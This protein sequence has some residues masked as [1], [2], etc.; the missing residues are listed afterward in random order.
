MA[1]RV[2]HGFGRRRQH[3]PRGRGAVGSLHGGPAQLLRA[4]SRRPDRLLHAVRR[5]AVPRGHQR[6]ERQHRARLRDRRHEEH[7]RRCQ[8]KGRAGGPRTLP[9]VRE[10]HLRQRV[11]RPGQGGGLQQ[12]ARSACRRSS[13][14]SASATRASAWART[15]C[16]RAR[17]ATTRWRPSPT[18]SC[19]T[20][21][22]AAARTGVCPSDWRLPRLRRAL[23][24]GPCGLRASRPWPGRGRRCRSRRRKRRRQR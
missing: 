1:R 3:E 2:R 12:A 4:V 5:G 13:R 18:T 19:A 11:D 20:S 17:Q 6:P 23:G 24:R 10:G 22:A 21:S 15:A 14:S 8:G 16:T 7:G 9:V